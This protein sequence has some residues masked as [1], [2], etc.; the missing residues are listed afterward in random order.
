MTRSNFG[1]SGFDL[2]LAA[3]GFAL[4]RS[5]ELRAALPTKATAAF[6]DFTLSWN[7]LGDD[8]YMADGGRYRRRRHAVFSV[9][10]KGI[11]RKPPQP[12]FQSRDYNPLNGGIQRV[13]EPIEPSVA[14]SPTMIGL[15]H[16]ADRIFTPLSSQRVPTWHVEVHQFRIEAG[17]GRPGQPTPEGLHR[18]GVDWVL[19]VLTARVN[20]A[21]GVTHI[22]ASGGE[23]L[24]AF[25]LA[26][27]L[28]AAFINDR[29]VC[30]AVT[31][32]VPIDPTRPAY[33]D[34]LVITFKIAEGAR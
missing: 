24:G 33:R 9:G 8:R 11:A 26:E 15:I 22:H 12:H 28:D 30:H 31:P 29:Q 32:V 6:A 19:V 4:V 10:P 23:S 25:C 14:T 21:Q 17:E 5:A 20:V 13:F 1:S 34:V 27:P 16:L 2:A 3:H 18:D 7:R